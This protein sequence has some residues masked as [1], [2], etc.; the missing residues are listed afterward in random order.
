MTS[1]YRNGSTSQVV[2]R[3]R[4]PRSQGAGRLISAC[5]RGDSELVNSIAGAEPSHDPAA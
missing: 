2:W 1:R 3:L 4:S 5:A